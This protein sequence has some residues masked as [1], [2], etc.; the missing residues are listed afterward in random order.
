MYK[1]THNMTQSTEIQNKLLWTTEPLVGLMDHAYQPKEPHKIGPCTVSTSVYTDIHQYNFPLYMYI[2]IYYI[3]Y[4]LISKYKFDLCISIHA[5]LTPFSIP[6]ILITSHSVSSQN[7]SISCLKKKKKITNTWR[8]L[9][10][11][12]IAHPFS[13]SEGILGKP[14]YHLSYNNRWQ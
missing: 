7:L 11:G 12:F 8:F 5:S 2:Y 13:V 14:L 9:M 3:I 10:K 6:V 4:I 1:V